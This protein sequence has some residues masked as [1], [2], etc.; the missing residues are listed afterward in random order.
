M[1]FCINMCESE[2]LGKPNCYP[3]TGENG[4]TGYNWKIPN[5]MGKIR[6]DQDKSSF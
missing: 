1:K 4:F 5:S 6:Y 3:T 2:Y